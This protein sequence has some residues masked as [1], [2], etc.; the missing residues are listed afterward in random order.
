[1]TS[2]KYFYKRQ[3][4]I[5]LYLAIGRLAI[6]IVCTLVV[7]IFTIV[8]PAFAL[9]WDDN[10]WANCPSTVEGIWISDNPDSINSKTLNIQKNRVSITQNMDGKVSFTGNIFLEK[11]NFIEMVLQSTTKEK[12]IHLKLRPHIVQTYSDS[13]HG[14]HCKVKVFQ[15]NS[16]A[17]AKF[18][19]YSR[20]DIYQLKRN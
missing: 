19:K 4:F 12:E 11:G 20:W 18:D 2:Q 3:G 15:F 16:Q 6:T 1:M 14:A 5:Q 9:D 7:L 17:H 13:E 8:L 10:E